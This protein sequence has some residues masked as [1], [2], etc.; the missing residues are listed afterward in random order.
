MPTAPLAAPIGGFPSRPGS[1]NGWK[2]EF[3]EATGFRLE[4]SFP[5][6]QGE[7]TNIG[8]KDEE[9]AEK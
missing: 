4:D 2:D 3:E 9:F 8:S 1:P 7:L 6:N 5:Q